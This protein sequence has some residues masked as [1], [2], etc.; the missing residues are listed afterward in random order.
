MFGIDSGLDQRL[1]LLPNLRI[2]FNFNVSPHKNAVVPRILF[3]LDRIGFVIEAEISDDLGVG[4]I[5]GADLT[6]AMHESI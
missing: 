3:A 1:H 6:S 4:R 5:G 2:T